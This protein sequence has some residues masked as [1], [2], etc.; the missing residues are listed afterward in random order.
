MEISAQKQRWSIH[1]FPP[2]QDLE[3][4]KILKALPSAHRAIAELK[5]I[6]QT[7]PNEIILLNTLPIQEAK[8]SSAIE[9]IV[10]THDEIFKAS[11]LTNAR[12]VE[13]KEVQ[14]YAIALKK[15]FS[16]IREKGILTKNDVIAIQSELEQNHAGIRRLP[17]T[18]LKNAITGE[19]VYTPPQTSEEIEALFSVL[20]QFMND[21]ELS[22]LDPL[23]KMAMIHFQFESIHPFYDGNGRTG[24]II[25]ILYLVLKGLLN[26]PILYLSRYIIEN[27]AQYYEL[28]QKVR[29]ENE[30]EEW[31]LYMIRGVEQTAHQS[32]R[33]IDAI[34][35][36]MQTYKHQIRDRYKFY[37]QDLLNN[38]F[39]HPYTRIDFIM[40]DLN[41]SRVTA[42]NYL[43]DL[44]KGGYLDRYKFGATNYYVNT[45]LFNLLLTY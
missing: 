12:S 45:L 36:L 24:R 38:L 27:K 41:V 33:L 25:N 37:S 31:L 7:I 8:D 26:L 10:T 3:S 29:D 20:E 4:K 9:N 39:K 15:G 35:T 40:Q 42:A 5:G 21:D 28:L 23:V 11:L 16:L 14:N 13:A 30:W 34:K 1:E 18:E 44:V 2:V 32:I 19:V 43:N 17:G 6:S 22:D